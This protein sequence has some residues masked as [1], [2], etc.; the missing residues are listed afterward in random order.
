MADS[1]VKSTALLLGM[2]EDDTE[3]EE[4]VDVGADREEAAGSAFADAVKS[5]DGAKI[6]AAFR[7]LKEACESGY[8]PE[9][10]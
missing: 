6:A 10:E 2:P 7:E 5:G 3:A 4:D 9:E 1:K 8:S